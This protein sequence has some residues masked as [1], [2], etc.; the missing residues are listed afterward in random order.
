MSAAEDRAREEEIRK[1]PVARAIFETIEALP[2]ST[3]L[4][5]DLYAQEVAAAVN[6]VLGDRV[7]RLERLLGDIEQRLLADDHEM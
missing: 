5:P 3:R 6:S 1:D 7:T 4:Y 2:H